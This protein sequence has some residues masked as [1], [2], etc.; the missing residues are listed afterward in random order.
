MCLQSKVE[1]KAAATAAAISTTTAA[2]GERAGT[3]TDKKDKPRSERKRVRK[4]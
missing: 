1:G 4:D 2:S 3:P